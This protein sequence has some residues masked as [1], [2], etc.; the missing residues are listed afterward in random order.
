MIALIIILGLGL[1]IIKPVRI[2]GSSM[3]PTMSNGDWAILLKCSYIISEP[4]RGD[5]I[6]FNNDYGLLMVKR[7][8]AL[9]T[10]FISV[11]KNGFVQVNP[12]EQ[13]NCQW[14]PNNKYYVL[15][16]NKD[17][18]IDSRSNTVKYI[19][20]KDILGKIIYKW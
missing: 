5:I 8:V 12:K 2:S 16:D 15:G 1:I 14:I 18:S 7:I 10:D 6:I 3:E 4:K 13:G 11:N 20:Q 17:N 9:P 19:D